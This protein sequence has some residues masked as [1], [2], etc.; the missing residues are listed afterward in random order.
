MSIRARYVKAMAAGMDHTCAAIE[1]E[2]GLYGYPPE[3]VCVGLVAIDEGRDPQA[4]IEQFIAD[5]Q[6]AA[7]VYDRT[8]PEY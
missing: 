3:T 7:D 1:K 5:A 2:H 4:E 8:H 6:H